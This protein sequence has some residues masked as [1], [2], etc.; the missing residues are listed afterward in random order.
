MYKEKLDQECSIRITVSRLSPSV[1]SIMLGAV[2]RYMFPD[3]IFSLAALLALTAYGTKQAI[4]VVQQVVIL[5]HRLFHRARLHEYAKD[6]QR[7][8]NVMAGDF[9]DYI[10]LYGTPLLWQIIEKFNS[11]GQ[12]DK[13]EMAPTVMGSLEEYRARLYDVTNRSEVPTY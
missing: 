3:S 11:L 12:G 10:V 7:Y 9:P 8:K 13:A 6:I 5:R 1:I 4:P 2:I